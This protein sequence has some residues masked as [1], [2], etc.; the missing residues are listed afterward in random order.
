MTGESWPD[1][2][3][4]MEHFITFTNELAEELGVRFEW[5]GGSA[6]TVRVVSIHDGM[7]CDVF[8]MGGADRVTADQVG[9]ACE[10]WLQEEVQELQNT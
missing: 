7:D 10:L 4:R 8:T 1:T 6:L 3:Q 5:A 9:Q 2:M